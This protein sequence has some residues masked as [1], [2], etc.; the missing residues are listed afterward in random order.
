MQNTILILLLTL[1]FSL[2][3]QEKKGLFNI[4]NVQ[5]YEKNN[6][7][8]YFIILSDG[9]DWKEI[10]EMDLKET[11]TPKSRKKVLE[12]IGIKEFDSVF[13]YSFI[14]NEIITFKV[15]DL[16]I[17][18]RE[19]AYGGYDYIAFDLKNKVKKGELDNYVE[20]YVFIGDQDPFNKGGMKPI[21]WKKIKKDKFPTVK[22]LATDFNKPFLF[23]KT[24]TLQYYSFINKDY[25][26][27]LKIKDKE[28][29]YNKVFHLIIK[30]KEKIVYNGFFHGSE[31]ATPAPLAFQQKDNSQHYEQWTGKLFKN[32]P[33][34]ILGFMYY[35]F[36]CNS[37]EFL[38]PSCNRLWVKCDARH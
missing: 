37:I 19:D 34:V 8:N 12:K 33:P 17:I 25:T 16:S 22:A 9:I 5:T 4:Y 23:N 28:D 18:T 2:K 31:G 35:S 27:Y 20:S 15:K 24:D 36:N 30:Q 29:M 7:E 13:I 6:K 26:Y 32:K 21:I 1:V 3:A 11:L 38:E 10:E 14:I